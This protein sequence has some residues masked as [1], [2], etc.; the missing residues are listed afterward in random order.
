AAGCG[1]EG[2]F[3]ILFHLPTNRTADKAKFVAELETLVKN[4]DE[5]NKNLRSSSGGMQVLYN[6][7]AA[8][9]SYCRLGIKAW[10]L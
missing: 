3:V 7:K 9:Y 1:K 10:P 6:V 2:E 8:D 4:T 5:K